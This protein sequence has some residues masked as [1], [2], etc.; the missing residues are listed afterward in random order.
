M[1]ARQ[2]VDPEV[3]PPTARPLG[4]HGQSQNASMPVKLNPRR[5]GRDAGKIAEE[6]IQHLT[7]EPGA[8]VEVVLDIQARLP[9]GATE[10][11]VRTVTENARTL[12]FTAQGFEAE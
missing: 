9:D 10:N 1:Q 2:P 12:K 4:V 5:A 11:I 8:E 7:L 6:I 3:S